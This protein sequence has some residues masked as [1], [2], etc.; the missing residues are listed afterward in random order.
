MSWG[1]YATE[2]EALA[3]PMPQTIRALHAAG[4]VRSGDP[5]RLVRNTVLDHLLDACEA[6][7]V[8]LGAYDHRVL[9]WLADHRSVAQ[10]V[11]G[12]IRRAAD[13]GGENRDG[14]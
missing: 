11:I 7:G 14:A 12:L 3:E 6:A 4:M 5:D 10:V 8:D 13:T 9:N 1:P 2:S